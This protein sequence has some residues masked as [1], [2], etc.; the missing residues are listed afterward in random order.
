MTFRLAFSGTYVLIDNFVRLTLV[1]Y[2]YL[3]YD[4]S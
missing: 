2:T 1:E 4:L 3:V